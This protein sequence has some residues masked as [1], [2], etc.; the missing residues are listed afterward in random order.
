M[1]LPPHRLPCARTDGLDVIVFP[2]LNIP[3]RAPVTMHP[4]PADSDAPAVPLLTQRRRILFT[5]GGI[6]LLAAVGGPRWPYAHAATAQPAAATLAQFMALSTW[7]TGRPVLNAELGRRYFDALAAQVAGF[8]SQLAT[9]ESL[10]QAH[11]QQ[12]QQAYC[13]AIDASGAAHASLPR[14]ILAAWYTGQVGKLPAPDAQHDRSSPPQPDAAAVV[15]AYE[16]ALMYPPTADVL[17]IPSYCRDVPGYWARQPQ[18]SAALATVPPTSSSSVPASPAAWSPTIWRRPAS[19]C[20]CSKPVRASSAAP[21]S[22]TSAT[23]PS[24]TTT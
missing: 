9:L 20:C 2:S 6:A 11:P 15:I 21:S 24:R 1:A 13:D 10:C 17:T 12:D 16:M 14:R 23:R 22:K 5:V 3:A 19:A 4:P 18:G 8:A 7:L